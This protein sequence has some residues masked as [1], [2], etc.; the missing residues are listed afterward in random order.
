MWAWANSDD[1]AVLASAIRASTR[2]ARAADLLERSRR[3]HDRCVHTDQPGIVSRISSVR[4]PSAVA[5]VPLDEVGLDLGALAE[6]GEGARVAGP[7]QRA[8][9]RRARRRCP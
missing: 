1:E 3:P 9:E 7:L 6:A 2:S 8:G 4:W 5:V